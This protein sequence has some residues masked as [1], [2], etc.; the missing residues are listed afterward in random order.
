[1]L[2]KSNVQKSMKYCGRAVRERQ[3]RAVCGWRPLSFTRAPI[4]VP[5]KWEILAPLPRQHVA[6]PAESQ[7]RVKA[8]R[9]RGP[10]P[11]PPTTHPSPLGRPAWQARAAPPRARSPTAPAAPRDPSERGL[12]CER[13]TEHT[14]RM[15]YLNKAGN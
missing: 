1:M 11:R 15:K 9:R 6:E 2:A 10:G 5:A 13:R 3:P 12:E 4:G 8:G 7:I 14:S